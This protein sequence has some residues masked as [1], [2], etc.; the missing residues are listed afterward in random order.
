MTRL[1]IGVDVG[2]TKVSAGVVS[3]EGE[4][5]DRVV[6]PTP[7]TD[8]GTEDFT[9]LLVELVLRLRHKNPAV[10][11]M[12]VG[13]PG[14]VEWP[15]G[16]IRWA[17]NNGYRD[18]PLRKILE[19]Q[20]DLPTAV[21]NDA[22]CAAWGEYRA[23]GGQ[24]CS[25]MLFVTVGTG[26]GGGLVLNG[27]LYRG[28]IG[29]AGEIGHMIVAADSARL[30]GCGN[31]GCLEAVASGTALASLGQS[32]ARND[33]QGRIARLAGEP[34]L[35]TGQTVYT[36]ASEGDPVACEL[37]DRI[38]FWLGA[39]LASL[40]NLLDFERIV[41]GGGLVACG[42]LLLRPTD[43]SYRELVLTA[44]REAPPTPQVGR[45]GPDAG[46]VGAA[47]LAFDEFR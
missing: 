25:D 19:A 30:C 34:D 14:L 35:V 42:N 29:R 4:I 2:G 24:P 6:V 43:A 21:D 33:P 45:F 26:V 44:G 28:R 3:E 17:P 7:P 39:G 8:C 16:Y 20:T 1:S 5:L 36:A 23:G 38:G 32:A 47:I 46:L 27:E 12:G 13:A 9:D 15:Q 37:F 18:L 10:A 40:V 31:V 22:N 11:A 41:L